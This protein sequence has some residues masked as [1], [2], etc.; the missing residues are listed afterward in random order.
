MEQHHN[1]S[2]LIIDDEEPICEVLVHAM[3]LWEMN[4]ISFTEASSALA[5][6]KEHCVDL[7]V[8]DVW[9]KKGTGL[10]LIPKIMEYCPNIKIIIMTGYADKETAIK[11]L[12][13]GVF[14]FLEKPLEIEILSHSITRALKAQEQE[15]KIK[16][17]LEDLQGNHA[18]L[19]QHKEHV[20]AMNTELIETNQALSVFAK[21]IKRERDQM[22]KRIASRLKAL[23]IPTVE[24]LK[25]DKR[26][27]RYTLE[28]DLLTK[29]INDL[30]TGFGS[31]TVVASNLSFSELKIASLIKNGLTN[32][33]IAEQ[34]SIS[35][36]T[37]KTHRKN[38][39]KKLGITNAHCGLRNFLISKEDPRH[40]LLAGSHDNEIKE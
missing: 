29:Q 2:I 20:E 4:A 19:Q 30:T 37:V 14:D 27:E 11:A 22:E 23:V 13:L 21:N 34:L 18:E 5:Y 6:I 25:R 1:A 39:R 3:E 24:K 12:R 38:I 36:N 28:L 9:L 7:I 31:N 35:P 16:R 40:D 33:E 8:L 26:L 15:R 32:D 10:A 17:L